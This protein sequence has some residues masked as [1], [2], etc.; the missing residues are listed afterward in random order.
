MK[1]FGV[2]ELSVIPVR[3]SP[4]SKSEMVTQLLYGEIFTIINFEEKW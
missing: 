4:V 3:K 1:K 2:C